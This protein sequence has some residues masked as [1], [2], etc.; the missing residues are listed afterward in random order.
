MAF[1]ARVVV[2]VSV[3]VLGAGLAGAPAF[4]HVEVEAD[5]AQAGARDVTVTFHG[6]AESGSAG[7]RSE[8]VVLPSGIAP[9]GVR[10]VKAPTGWKFTAAADGFTVAGPALKVGQDAEF[11]VR[12]AQLPADATTLSFKTLET[13]G[14]GEI[15][16]WIELPEAGRPE[17]DHPAP[18]IKLKAAAEPAGPTAAP[19][20][21]PSAAPSAPAETSAA[22]AA[23]GSST[24]AADRAD[25]VE[26]GRSGAVWWIVPAV[27]LIAAVTGLLLWRRR[28]A[29]A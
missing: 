29:S 10:L 6:E 27:V 7:I 13:Y 24:A 26:S 17:P 8:R 1:S 2:A 16:R 20:A 22:P 14:D 25:P 15:A 18:T 11:A 28:T 5:K 9:A 4:A 23:A 21:G 12:L 3:G 19:S